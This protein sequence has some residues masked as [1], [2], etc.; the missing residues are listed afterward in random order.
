MSKFVTR[1]NFTSRKRNLLTASPALPS[2]TPSTSPYSLRQFIFIMPCKFP[3]LPTNSLLSFSRSL[4]SFYNPVS[5]KF[6]PFLSNINNN[7]ICRVPHWHFHTIDV[8]YS[9]FKWPF[10]VWRNNYRILGLNEQ[11]SYLVIIFLV[12]FF[13][14]KLSQKHFEVTFF[15]ILQFCTSKEKPQEFPLKIPYAK[16]LNR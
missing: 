2:V 9:W 1:N 14:K 16:Q 12:I 10:D 15:R 4:S 8:W 5:L 13:K 6:K 3:P 7:R 11:P